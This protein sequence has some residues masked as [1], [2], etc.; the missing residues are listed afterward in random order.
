MTIEEA[1]LEQGLLMIDLK[2]PELKKVLRS[3]PIKSAKTAP[4]VLTHKKK[5]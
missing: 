5:K 2:R 3:I 1:H 4:K